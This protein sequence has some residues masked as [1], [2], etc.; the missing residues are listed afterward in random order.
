MSMPTTIDAAA[1][2]TG[3]AAPIRRRPVLTGD[4]DTA[5]LVAAATAGDRRAWE[6]LVERYSPTVWAVAR[7]HRL[8]AADAADV[9]QTTWMRL[10]ENLM[11]I[12]EP[13]RV[14]AWLATTARRECLGVL[15]RSARQVASGQDFDAIRD[16]EGSRNPARMLMAE[17]RRVLV[18]ELV[19]QLPIR[20]QILLRLLAAD[21]PL[22]YLEISEALEMPVGSIGPTRARALSQLRRLAA[23]ANLEPE[24]IFYA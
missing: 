11:R 23:G 14:G 4:H 8:N 24:D 9:F 1:L 20:S 16:V 17:E 7:G 15:R 21:T 5:T 22:S 12:H 3:G 13:Q 2:P 6:L 19:R 18:D 10:F